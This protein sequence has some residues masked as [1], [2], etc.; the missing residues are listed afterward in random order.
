MHTVTEEKQTKT[1]P[2]PTNQPTNQKGW[3]GEER[4]R[5]HRQLGQREEGGIDRTKGGRGHRQDKG[6]K[7]A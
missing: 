3:E 7:G 1:I 6:R 5:G 2:Q 4:G